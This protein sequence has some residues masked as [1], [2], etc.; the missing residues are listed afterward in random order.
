MPVLTRSQTKMWNA[1]NAKHEKR[2]FGEWEDCYAVIHDVGAKYPRSMP[3]GQIWTGPV[4]W[5]ENTALYTTTYFQTYGGGPEGG[6]FVVYYEENNG[7]KGACACY[8][9]HRTWGE[10]FR[11]TKNLTR[12]GAR[13]EYEPE[14]WR[15]GKVSQVR[16]SYSDPYTQ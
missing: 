11:I 10:S 9:V 3:H 4:R 15:N 2:V 13:L 5:G 8:E 12:I 14:D 6:Y 7:R 16:Y 1:R